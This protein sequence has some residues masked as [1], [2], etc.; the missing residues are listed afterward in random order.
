MRIHIP[1]HSKPSKNIKQQTLYGGNTTL[2]IW[3]IIRS[4]KT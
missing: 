1:I 2:N 3:Q 4:M